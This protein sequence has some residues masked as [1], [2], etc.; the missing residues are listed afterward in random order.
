M[1]IKINRQLDINFQEEPKAVFRQ[2]NKEVLLFGEL[3]GIFS[4]ITNKLMSPNESWQRICHSFSNKDILADLLV[5]SVGSFL[6]LIKQGDAIQIYSSPR[7]PG[8]FYGHK[9]GEL[10]L[11]GNEKKFY[12]AM[13]GSRTNDFE[14]LHMLLHHPAVRSPF[15]TLLQDGAAFHDEDWPD[16]PHRGALP[17]PDLGAQSGTS[18]SPV[19]AVQRR[20][21]SSRATPSPDRGSRPGQGLARQGRGKRGD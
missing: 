6:V 10:V 15:T 1:N 19:V 20:P 17:V 5:N 12:Q 8:V 18:L 7:G 2:N 9:N 14:V 3:D 4:E 21:G 13:K 11:I 16:P